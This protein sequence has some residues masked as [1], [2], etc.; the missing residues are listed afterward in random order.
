MLDLVTR[1]LDSLGYAGLA[2]LMFLENV[3]PPIPAELIMPLAGYDAARGKGDLA[4]VI[5]AGSLGSLAGATFWYGVGRWVGPER[6]R[7]WAARHGRWLTLTPAAIARVAR[8]FAGRGTLAVL[9]GRLVPGVRTY[10][11][12][13]AGLFGMKLTPFL[14]YSAIGTFAWTAILAIAGYQLGARYAL[15]GAEVNL[16][17]NVALTLAVGI[18]LVRVVRWRPDA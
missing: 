2:L 10:I 17:S 4:M 16:V 5:V 8:W 7:H 6:L 13:P 11:S 18:Y 3:F 14:L 12:I 9:V 15:V 1:M